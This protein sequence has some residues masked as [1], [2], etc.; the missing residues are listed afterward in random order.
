MTGA[1]LADIIRRNRGEERRSEITEYGASI[2]RTQLAAALGNI[3]AVS[4]GAVVF[5]LIWAAGVPY[6]LC[7]G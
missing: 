6:A 1:A 4:S 3:L 2:S 7:A 5:N